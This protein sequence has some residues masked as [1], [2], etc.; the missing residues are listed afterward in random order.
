MSDPTPFPSTSTP[1]T[2]E[3]ITVSTGLSFDALVAA[4]EAQL[5]RWDL[6][7]AQAVI[8]QG[9]PVLESKIHTMEGPHGLMIVSTADQGE[10]A[11]VSDPAIRCTLYE[12]G[13]PA[14]ATGIL[15]IDIRA[16]LLVPFKVAL[17]EMGRGTGATLV[18][19]RPSSLLA[20]LSNPKLVD[21]GKGLDTKMQAVVDAIAD[22][23]SS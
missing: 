6:A 8:P 18:Y 14:V 19:D 13:N 3:R 16:C 1:A 12:I 7:A 15:K 10:I 5:G 23:A 4:F 21:I 22:S 20:T 2:T 9:W 17:Y 11:S